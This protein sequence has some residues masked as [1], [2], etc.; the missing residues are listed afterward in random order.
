MEREYPKTK[1]EKVG[2]ICRVCHK[3]FII[4]TLQKRESQKIKAVEKNLEVTEKRLKVLND[5][6]NEIEAQIDG[7]YA[8]IGIKAKTQKLKKRYDREFDDLE[9]EISHI[10]ETLDRVQSER[11]DTGA[12]INYPM[13]S[14][15]VPYHSNPKS[16][17]NFDKPHFS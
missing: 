11:N 12:T 9:F 13:S 2:N 17:F 15:L 5:G 4:K 14:Y 7:N 16:I 10:E 8:G 6:I 3:R 1:C